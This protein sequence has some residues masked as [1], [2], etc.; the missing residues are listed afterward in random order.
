[1]AVLLQFSLASLESGFTEFLTLSCL[2]LHSSHTFSPFCSEKCFML[3]SY[4]TKSH[5][6]CSH[7]PS[8]GG[9]SVTVTHTLASVSWPEFIK[10][11][12]PTVGTTQTLWSWKIHRDPYEFYSLPFHFCKEDQWNFE[13][14]CI[15]STFL[16]ASYS[17]SIYHIWA[18]IL[19]HF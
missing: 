15:G 10:W 5:T 17:Y 2:L 19:G 7:T 3:L 13:R 14:N 9:L 8:T 18:F 11:L 4:G 12:F 6:S 16:V 1:M